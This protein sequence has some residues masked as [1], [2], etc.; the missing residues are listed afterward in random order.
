MATIHHQVAIAASP[1]EVYAALASADGIGTWWDQQKAV[2]TSEGLVLEHDPGPKHGVV[3]LRV[4]DLIPNARVEWAC[5]S[6]HPASSPASVWT[7]T[8]FIFEMSERDS[9]AATAERESMEASR[10]NQARVTTLDFRQTGYDET[11]EFAGF[12]NF[13]WAQ[14]LGNLKRV[15]ESQSS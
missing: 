6:T 2:H 1:A 11:S 13:A 3:R 4:V 12:N 10:R 8:H 15:C 9:A 14:V 7:G 5:I